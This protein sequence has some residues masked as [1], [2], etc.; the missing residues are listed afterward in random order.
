MIRI[1]A[2]FSFILAGFFAAT[3]EKFNQ[4]LCVFEYLGVNKITFLRELQGVSSDDYIMLVISGYILIIFGIILGFVKNKIAWGVL[5]FIALCIELI[6][7]RMIDT[8]PYTEIIYDSIF[9]CSNYSLMGWLIFHVIA[10]VL[11]VVYFARNN[12]E[13]W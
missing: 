2:A 4:G 13:D 11:S 6:L 3:V 7:L 1:F 9:K 12:Y 8:A 5:L 10:L